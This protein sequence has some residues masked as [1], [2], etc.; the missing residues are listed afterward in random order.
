LFQVDADNFLSFSAA[1]DPV[2]EPGD[3]GED[4]NVAGDSEEGQGQRRSKKNAKWDQPIHTALSATHFEVF[5]MVFHLFIRHRMT[6]SLVEDIFKMINSILGSSV[7]NTCKYVFKKLFLSSN[8]MIIHIYCPK[9]DAYL[10]ERE[11]LIEELRN[12]LK[13]NF[14]E[15]HCSVTCNRGNLCNINKLDTNF[16]VTVGI[17]DLSRHFM[18]R[19]NVKLILPDKTSGVYRDVTDGDLYD[20]LIRS[21]IAKGKNVLTLLFILMEQKCIKSRCGLC[22]LLLTSWIQ[23]RGSKTKTSFCVV[24]GTGRGPQT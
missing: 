6:Y 1:T 21:E 12:E 23:K 4:D 18:R 16:F 10:G 5:L 11:R 14:E 15:K 19:P 17:R 9:C 22:N 3:H 24:C 8:K 13:E 20:Q 2:N 7:L